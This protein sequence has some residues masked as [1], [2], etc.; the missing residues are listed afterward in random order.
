MVTSLETYSPL[1]VE[2]RFAPAHC[3]V[4]GWIDDD[5]ALAVRPAP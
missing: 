2:T 4:R 5:E 1:A 3:M